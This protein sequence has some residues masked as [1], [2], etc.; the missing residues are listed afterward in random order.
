MSDHLQ[1]RHHEENAM[2]VLCYVISA[3]SVALCLFL[4]IRSI[5][6]W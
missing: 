3:A 6:G 5:L 4:L 1:G 2:C